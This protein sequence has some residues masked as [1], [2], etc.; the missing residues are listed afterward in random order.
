M[1]AS[2]G[3]AGRVEAQVRAL[4]PAVDSGP[5]RGEPT[6]MRV[7]HEREELAET[8]GCILVPTMGALHE[9]HASL[10]R[11][12]ATEAARLAAGGGARPPVVV[13]IFVNPTQFELKD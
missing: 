13:T 9:G 10:V 6:P 11:I 1:T 4:A 8:G 3:I 5:A 12:G 2:G 7:V